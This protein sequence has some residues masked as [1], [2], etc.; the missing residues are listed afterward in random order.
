MNP[1]LTDNITNSSRNKTSINSNRQELNDRTTKKSIMPLSLDI[2]I[3]NSILN[4]TNTSVFAQ[5]N[6]SMFHEG[7]TTS[8]KRSQYNTEIKKINYESKKDNVMNAK[9][10]LQKYGNVLNDYEKGEI[11]DYQEIY[12]LGDL[13]KKKYNKEIF[14]DHKGYYDASINSHIAYRYE[15]LEEIG[16]GSFGQALKCYDHKEKKL[17]ALKILKKKRNLYHQGMVEAK[18][19]RFIKEN[20]PDGKFHMVKMI[21][22]FLFRKHITI[23]TELLS[24]NLYTFL[25]KNNFHGI[26]LKLIK[27][28]AI[29]I[30]ESLW[31]LRKYQI[32]HCDLKP[33]NILLEQSNRSSIKLIDFGSSCFNNEKIYTYIQSRFYRAPEVMLG[34]PYT[35]GI[36]MWSTGC[37]LA[38]LFIGYPLFP[39]KNEPEQMAMILEVN[40][41][42]PKHILEKATRKEVF[43]DINE[44]PFPVKNNHGQRKIP[45]SKSLDEIIGC[46]DPEFIDFIHKCLIWDPSKRMTPDEAITHPWLADKSKAN[47]P[48][49]RKINNFM[50]TTQDSCRIKGEITTRNDQILNN[51]KYK[52]K[53][54]DK[55]D[56]EKR[57]I[58]LNVIN[59]KQ[60]I[61]LGNDMKRKISPK[62][63]RLKKSFNNKS[64]S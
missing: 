2:S 15:I 25:E 63:R 4:T 48:I 7:I 50:N 42:P 40:G 22:Y 44:I 58:K 1:S 55:G 23:V 54:M 29:Q 27:R 41:L 19:L 11:L 16:K 53:S 17:V 62:T 60:L 21:E 5:R 18:I 9:E 8:L 32:I 14:T 26:S 46:G 34:I 47:F 59:K 20:D 28:F 31:F 61:P 36:D 51:K 52:S 10:A 38:E 43:F 39:G 6:D 56:N 3:N 35:T 12:F 45:G 57:I 24:M 37:I 49:S 13:N 30:M 33:E 64:Q